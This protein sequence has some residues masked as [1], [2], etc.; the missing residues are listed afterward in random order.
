MSSPLLN[1]PEFITECHTMSSHI[2]GSTAKYRSLQHFIF[3][4]M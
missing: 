1:D 4:R 3:G 2:T